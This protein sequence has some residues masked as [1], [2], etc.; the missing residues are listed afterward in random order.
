MGLEVMGLDKGKRCCLCNSRGCE[1]LLHEID[2]LV[3][4]ADF[5]VR[6][7]IN[8]MKQHHATQVFS[9]A[10]SQLNNLSDNTLST[11]KAISY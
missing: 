7:P 4:T 8:G 1:P 3:D 6:C 11:Y 10:S 5:C 9:Q 2:H